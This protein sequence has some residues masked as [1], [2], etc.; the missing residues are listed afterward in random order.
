MNKEE[1]LQEIEKT[2]KHLANMEKMLG[3]HNKRWKPK[4]SEEY[5]WQIYISINQGYYK[6]INRR[7][8][9]G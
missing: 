2:K 9:N 1:I 4:P 5:Y 6:Q 7:I 3:E 8:I